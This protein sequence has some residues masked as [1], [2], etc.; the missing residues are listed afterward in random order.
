M[1]H[2]PPKKNDKDIIAE[3]AAAE[4]LTDA[5]QAAVDA[6]NE[7]VSPNPEPEAADDEGATAPGESAD[8]FIKFMGSA[9]EKV[10]EVGDDAQ[11]SLPA[12][13][14]R[15]RFHKGNGW[16]VNAAKFPTVPSAWWDYLVENDNFIDA[17][18]IVAAEKQVPPNDH[19]TTFQGVKGRP[20]STSKL[21]AAYAAQADA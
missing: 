8:R 17:T 5:E 7:P 4:P 15:L 6:A 1:S 20:A 11:N 3:D 14:E 12:L 21:D 18:S 16:M 10:I 19:Q 9:D 2:M 13:K